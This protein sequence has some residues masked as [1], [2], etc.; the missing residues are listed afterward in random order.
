[1]SLNRQLREEM[2]KCFLVQC[3]ELST[4]HVYTITDFI[5]VG[6]AEFLKINRMK[7]N[8]MKVVKKRNFHWIRSVRKEPQRNGENVTKGQQRNHVGCVSM[9]WGA[10]AALSLLMIT[11]CTMNQVLFLLTKFGGS[12]S[13]N[14]RDGIQPDCVLG[15]EKAATS[16]KLV[17]PSQAVARPF[18]NEKSNTFC[19]TWHLFCLF[20]K[21]NVS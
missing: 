4:L 14:G 18:E 13:P 2:L 10:L 15:S 17:S 19:S 6:K 9:M 7:E 3:L 16:S 11:G 8:M 20:W 21:K 1:M 12:L 5:Q